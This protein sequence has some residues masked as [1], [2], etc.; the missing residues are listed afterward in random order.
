MFPGTYTPDFYRVLHR[1]VHK[2]FRV[3][4]GLHSTRDLLSLRM[5]PGSRITRSIA[6]MLYHGATLPVSLTKLAVLGRRPLRGTA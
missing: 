5:I 1:V 2:K 4:H 3:W 6:S